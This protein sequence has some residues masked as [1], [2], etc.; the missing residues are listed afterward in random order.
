MDVKLVIT[1]MVVYVWVYY[2]L[3]RRVL[4]DIRKV[5][6]DYFEYSGARG[7]IGMENSLA[8][9]RMIFDGGMPKNFY[10]SVI[11]AKL[12]IVRVMLGAAPVVFVALLLMG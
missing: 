7:G 10:P 4:T 9:G 6:P 8:V 1:L 2:F 3:A 12:M 5:D 11:K